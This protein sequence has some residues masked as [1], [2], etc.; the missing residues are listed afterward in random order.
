MKSVPVK[1]LLSE[2]QFFCWILQ[3][4]VTTAMLGVIWTVQ[5]VLY[6]QFSQIG[7]AEFASYHAEYSSRITWIVG[8]LMLAELAL[9]L[10]G[11]GFFWATPLRWI[12]LIGLLLVGVIWIVTA[13]V[14]IPVHSRLSQ[15]L[16][17]IEVKSLVSGNWIRTIAWSVRAVLVWWVL[18]RFLG[19]T[20]AT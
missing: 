16:D 9:A 20:S 18:I 19:S 14:Q 1:M 4:L 11:V 13:V 12:T 2:P 8:P 17:Q 15:G 5:L 6:P 3:A 7:E 10:V